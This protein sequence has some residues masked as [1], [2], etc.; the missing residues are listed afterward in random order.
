VGQLNIYD[1]VSHPVLV[2]PVE[3]ARQLEQKLAPTPKA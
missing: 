1:V 2:L 3:A